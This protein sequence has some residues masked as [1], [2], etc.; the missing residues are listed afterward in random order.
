MPGRNGS[1]RVVAP[2]C[3]D[4]EAELRTMREGSMERRR[5]AEAAIHSGGVISDGTVTR[6]HEATG[7]ALLVPGENF[8]EW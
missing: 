6:T 3:T 2:T 4:L 1:E 8:G 5:L 7:E